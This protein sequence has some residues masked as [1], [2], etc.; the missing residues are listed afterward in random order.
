MTDHARFRYSA[1]DFQSWDAGR[2]AIRP[3]WQQLYAQIGP[4][5]EGAA[6]ILDIAGGEG[7]THDMLPGLSPQLVT[8]DIDGA[9]LGRLTDKHPAAQVA[10]ANVGQ[11]PFAD[12]SFEAAIALNAINRTDARNQAEEIARIL[13][14]GGRLIFLYDLSTSAHSMVLDSRKGLPADV[15]ADTYHLPVIN[16][17]TRTIDQMFGITRAWLHHPVLEASV[18]EYVNLD[19]IKELLDGDWVEEIYGDPLKTA[20]YAKLFTRLLAEIRTTTD[21]EVPLY[22]PYT[23]LQREK[24]IS[25]FAALDSVTTTVEMIEVNHETEAAHHIEG[26]PVSRL[27]VDDLSLPHIIYKADAPSTKVKGRTPVFTVTKK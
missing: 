26:E 23:P 10:E 21:R 14:P 17:E 16:P 18:S 7:R 20:T 8:V 25:G 9:A 1:E 27:Y 12:E 22:E 3:Y 4:R 24:D 2:E 11:L 6:Q 5:L 15:A 13:K 19:E